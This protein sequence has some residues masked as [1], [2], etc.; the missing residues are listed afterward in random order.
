MHRF[1]PNNLNPDVQPVNGI[2]FRGD[3][4]NPKKDGVFE[5]GFLDV[6]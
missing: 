2:G 6:P 5:E 3:S 1:N 4:R